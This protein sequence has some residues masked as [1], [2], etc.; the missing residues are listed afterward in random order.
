MTFDILSVMLIVFIISLFVWGL[1]RVKQ[2]EK[3]EQDPKKGEE[4]NNS[5]LPYNSKRKNLSQGGMLM[6]LAEK[7]KQLPSSPGVY[8]MKSAE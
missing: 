1:W 7:V 2:Y 6:S 4:K 3:M 5:P 8:L